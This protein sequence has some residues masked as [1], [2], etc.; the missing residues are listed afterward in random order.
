[1]VNSGAREESA[2]PTFYD[3]SV[4]LLLYSVK[5]EKSRGRGNKTSTSKGKRSTVITVNQIDDDRKLIGVYVRHLIS[6]C[7][8]HM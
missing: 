4:V 2:V 8:S 7:I 6:T 5:Y 1:V 3:T